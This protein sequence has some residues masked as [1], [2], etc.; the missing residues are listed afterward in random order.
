MT[1]ASTFRRDLF[2]GVTV[3]VTG[4]G[5]GIGAGVAEAFA[6]CGADLALHD[7]DEG[8]LHARAE[9][10]RARGV[11][12]KTFHADLARKGAAE[13]L[14]A[15]VIDSAGQVH[16]LVNNAGCSWA[17]T[18]DE[19]DALTRCPCFG[20]AGRSCSIG[21]PMAAGEASCRFPR[22]QVSPASATG[23]STRPPSMPCRD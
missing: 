7:V 4:G 12:V 21:K 3:L 13:T 19:I 2:A 1:A 14:M 10:L 18:T 22:L 23:L 15:E 20:C 6:D 9:S 16:V 8:A 17:V 11:D 5:R